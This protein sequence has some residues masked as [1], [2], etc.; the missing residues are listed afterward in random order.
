MGG[1]LP[2]EAGMVLPKMFISYDRRAEPKRGGISI[3]NIIYYKERG[4]K[5][6]AYLISK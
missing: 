5:G 4:L 3:L 1:C 2:D 6:A